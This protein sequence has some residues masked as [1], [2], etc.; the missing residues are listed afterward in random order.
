MFAYAVL[1]FDAFEAEAFGFFVF[2]GIL[3]DV[4][5]FAQ[6][7]QFFVVSRVYVETL[8]SVVFGV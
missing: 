7:S 3:G 5:L 8:Y 2:I 6:S 1:D 4:V